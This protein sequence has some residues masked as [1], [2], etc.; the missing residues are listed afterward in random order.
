MNRK[1]VDIDLARIVAQ[2]RAKVKPLPQCAY[3]GTVIRQFCWV[4]TPKGPVCELCV[5]LNRHA[6]VTEYVNPK[7]LEDTCE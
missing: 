3:C 1:V 4:V 6:T 2:A 5:S 7:T